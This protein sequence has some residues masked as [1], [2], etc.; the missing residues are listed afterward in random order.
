MAATPILWGCFVKGNPEE[1]LKLSAAFLLQAPVQTG[2]VRVLIYI[3]PECGDIGCGAYSARISSSNSAYIWESF[4]YENGYEEPHI[5][6]GIGPFKFDRHMYES[7]IRSA[8]A[9]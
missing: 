5:I 1:N 2:S 8:A 3:C 7:A 4:A 6:K 9:P